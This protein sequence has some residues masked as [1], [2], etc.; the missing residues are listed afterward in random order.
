M[1][2]LLHFQEHNVREKFVA[3]LQN[4]FP[5]AGLTFAIGGQISIDVFPN[6]WDKRFCLQFLLKDDIKTI[7]FFGDKTAKVKICI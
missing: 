6:G 5:D 7:H 4:E 1:I 2:F 3:A